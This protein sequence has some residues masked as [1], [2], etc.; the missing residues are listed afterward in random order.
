[1]LRYY[2][3]T[4]KLQHLK[5]AQENM[6][7]HGNSQYRIWLVEQELCILPE[8]MTS[9]RVF[10]GVRI[11]QSFVFCVGFCRSL[12]DILSFFIFSQLY[13]L[14]LVNLQLLITTL[15]SF[16]NQQNW[17]HKKYIHYILLT[18]LTYKWK[19]CLTRYIAV[20]L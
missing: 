7:H 15:V 19:L 14:S 8:H 18:K 3:Y 20:F 1:M 2:P 9:P 4:Y 16:Q 11:D 13:C 10:G 5:H 12:F 17:W 6:C